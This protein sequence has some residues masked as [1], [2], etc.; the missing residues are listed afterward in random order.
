MYFEISI[1]SAELGSVATSENLARLS[2]NS[3]AVHHCSWNRSAMAVATAG[4]LP[5]AEA[6]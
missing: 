2:S 1:L 4:R 3:S 5:P 6:E